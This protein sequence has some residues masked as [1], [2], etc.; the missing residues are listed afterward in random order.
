MNNDKHLNT[1][2]I[3]RSLKKQYPL[4]YLRRTINFFT[5]S[6]CSGFDTC[7]ITRSRRSCKFIANVPYYLIEYIMYTNL[8]SMKYDKEWE[9]T[10]NA[11]SWSS[12]TETGKSAGHSRRSKLDHAGRENIGKLFAKENDIQEDHENQSVITRYRKDGHMLERETR[13][14]PKRKSVDRAEWRRERRRCWQHKEIL[15]IRS[16]NPHWNERAMFSSNRIFVTSLLE[17]RKWSKPLHK[18]KP[19][20]S[21]SVEQLHDWRIG[22][23]DTD[24]YFDLQRNIS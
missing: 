2:D 23:D 16:W 14:Y 12:S 19:A 15:G 4:S 20:E 11:F 7:K 13:V 3:Q 18:W 17:K 1:S 21:S 6:K 9:T 8:H 5:H 10:S 22:L 24:H